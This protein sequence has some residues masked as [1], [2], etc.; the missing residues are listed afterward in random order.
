MMRR[1]WL[2]TAWRRGL[3]E[4]RWSN[5]VEVFDDYRCEV[6]CCH[7]LRAQQTYVDEEHG[8]R[9]AVCRSGV[10]CHVTRNAGGAPR[11]VDEEHDS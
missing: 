1:Q 2:G 11:F 3:R 10:C 6:K 5:E 4:I 8:E 9:D 7:G